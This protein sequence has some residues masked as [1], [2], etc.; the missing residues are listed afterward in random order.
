M[1]FA[2]VPGCRDAPKNESASSSHSSKVSENT[3]LAN[4]AAPQHGGAVRHV[5]AVETETIVAPSGHVAVFVRDAKGEVN[6]KR[7]A[8]TVLAV[9]DGKTA[10]FELEPDVK[11][12]ALHGD[13]PRPGD[14]TSLRIDLSIDGARVGKW[15]LV[16]GIEGTDTTE[17]IG[18]G[19]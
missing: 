11:E 16:V 13:G 3:T 7:L 6:V 12:N 14:H 5:G 18:D 19:D 8:A 1:I 2:Q 17:P 4:A 15:S 10:S 9:S